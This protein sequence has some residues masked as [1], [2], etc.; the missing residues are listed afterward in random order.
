MP[1]AIKRLFLSALA[2]AWMTALAPSANATTTTTLKV[3]LWGD[4]TGTMPTDMGMGMSKTKGTTHGANANMGITI[5]RKSIPTGPVAFEVKNNA[6]NSIHEMLVL[7]IK[8][9]S[10]P[11]PYLK[12]ESRLDETKTNS[13]G[14]VSELDPGKS[15]TL[16]VTLKPGKYL[17]VCNVPGH[18]AAGMWTLL[19]VRPAPPVIGAL[20]NH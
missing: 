6:E 4:M 18:Y 5:Y 17:L 1:H 10:T 8:N 16:K 2:I 13:L 11:L 12:N 15:G 9:T 20:Q 14:E 3:L 7:P 19:T